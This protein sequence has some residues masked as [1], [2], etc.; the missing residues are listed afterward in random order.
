M[1]TA[2]IWTANK[3]LK[4]LVG[5]GRLPRIPQLKM[6][7]AAGRAI[8]TEDNTSK[9]NLLAKTFFPPLPDI[10]H[11]DDYLEDYPDPLPDP[12]IISKDQVAEHIEKLPPFKA[13]S[14]DGIPNIMLKECSKI[15]STPLTNIFKALINL[16]TYYKPWREF[17]TVVLRKPGKPSYKT[18]KAY[19]PITLISTMAKLLTGI[20]AKQLNNTVE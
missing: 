17:T 10:I 18:P 13:V 7:N 16:N 5:D 14:P 15:L 3:Y 12:P 20:M 19:R 4:E 8:S 1:S 9:A 6:T 2:E 11:N